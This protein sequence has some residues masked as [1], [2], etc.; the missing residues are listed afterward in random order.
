[1][2]SWRIWL[3][4]G[5]LLLVLSINATTISHRKKA[6]EIKPILVPNVLIVKLTKCIFLYALEIHDYICFRDICGWS[7][8]P[9]PMANIRH[10][11][12]PDS[13]MR[14][15]TYMEIFT[16]GTHCCIGTAREES[17]NFCMIVSFK[18]TEIN[19]NFAIPIASNSSKCMEF[20]NQNS[21][22][23][24]FLRRCWCRCNHCSTK[25]LRAERFAWISV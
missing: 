8:R 11:D 23:D 12:V 3:Y 19:H 18:R 14:A 2:D 6:N 17:W 22:S 15:F 21:D 24:H 9:K 4:L 16:I 13:I 10:E 25:W 20:Y 7:W 5:W 1:M